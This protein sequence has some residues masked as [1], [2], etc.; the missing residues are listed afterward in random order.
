MSVYEA[1]T[2]TSTTRPLSPTGQRT[3]P[4]TGP[5]PPPADAAT[6]PADRLRQ[7]LRHHAAGVVIVTGDAGGDPVGLTATSFTSVSL[8]PP[9]VGFYIAESSSTWPQ[10]RQTGEF[11]VHLL[12][13]GQA[14]LAAR[15]ATK[16]AD[17]F[18]APTR[19]TR[20]ANNVPLLSDA[21]AHLVCRWHDVHRLGD[22]WLVVGEVTDTASPTEPQA[23]LLYHQ[24]SFGGFTAFG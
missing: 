2:A 12:G 5:T 21:I 9:L 17:R 7:T 11:A 4:P 23:P 3:I 1:R 6:V 10:L 8:T 13:S 19:W 14:D 24:G 22:H 18:A 20:G 15:F 16:G